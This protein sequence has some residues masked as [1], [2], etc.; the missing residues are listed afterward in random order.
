MSSKPNTIRKRRD[1]LE[2]EGDRSVADVKQLKRHLPDLFDAGF[3][4]E[5]IQKELAGFSS[6]GIGASIKNGLTD[7]GRNQ[8]D[9][10]TAHLASCALEALKKHSF[11]FTVQHESEKDEEDEFVQNHNI[12]VGVGNVSDFLS[13]S[14]KPIEDLD[15]LCDFSRLLHH[16]RSVVD[17][18]KGKLPNFRRHIQKFEV[19]IQTLKGELSD[20][21]EQEKEGTLTRSERIQKEQ[22][23]ADIGKQQLAAAANKKNLKRRQK[24]ISDYEQKIS[25]ISKILSDFLSQFDPKNPQSISEKLKPDMFTGSI[26]YQQADP[27]VLIAIRRILLSKRRGEYSSYDVE[28]ASRHR[29]LKRKEALAKWSRRLALPLLLVSGV[30]LA[31]RERISDAVFGPQLNAEAFAEA[32]LSMPNQFRTEVLLKHNKKLAVTKMRILRAIESPLM[33]NDAKK[34]SQEIISSI[35]TATNPQSLTKALNEVLH[36]INYM[37]GKEDTVRLF[38]D[39]HYVKLLKGEFGDDLSLGL[40]YWNNPENGKPLTLRGNQYTG[41]AVE[42]PKRQ[43]CDETGKFNVITYFE[44]DG[45]TYEVREIADIFSSNSKYDRQKCLESIDDPIERAEK[46]AEY[47]REGFTDYFDDHIVGGKINT[48][49]PYVLASLHVQQAK[50]ES[51]KKSLIE[52]FK[53]VF[54][55]KQIKTIKKADRLS[56]L[57]ALLLE[58]KALSWHS[59]ESQEDGQLKIAINP[60]FEEAFKMVF[61]DDTEV[62]LR[63]YGDTAGLVRSG[64]MPVLNQKEVVVDRELLCRP[65]LLVGPGLFKQGKGGGLKNIYRLFQVDDPIYEGICT[66]GLYPPKNASLDEINQ[67]VEYK[68]KVLSH[69]LIEGRYLDEN[70]RLAFERNLDMSMSEEERRFYVVQLWLTRIITSPKFKEDFERIYQAHSKLG[71]INDQDY[72]YSAAMLE[73]DQKDVEDSLKR[74][75]EDYYFFSPPHDLMVDLIKHFGKDIDVGYSADGEGLFMQRDAQIFHVKKEDFCSN[76]FKT[77]DLTFQLAFGMS[78]TDG[79]RIERKI[80]EQDAE[81][82]FLKACMGKYPLVKG[83]QSETRREEILNH[84]LIKNYLVPREKEAL[85]NADS[86]MAFYRRLNSTVQLLEHDRAR[87]EKDFKKLMRAHYL[88]NSDEIKLFPP[89]NETFKKAVEDQFGPDCTL[90]IGDAGL[91]GS[92]NGA[93]WK[94]EILLTVKSPVPKLIPSLSFKIPTEFLFYGMMLDRS[95]QPKEPYLK[96]AL[97]AEDLANWDPEETIVNSIL[98]NPFLHEY[99]SQEYMKRLSGTNSFEEFESILIEWLESMRVDD[100]PKLQDDLY[101]LMQTIPD[102]AYQISM[103]HTRDKSTVVVRVDRSDKMIRL[104]EGKYGKGIGI[105]LDW[106]ND[107]R[108]YEAL[109]PVDFSSSRLEFVMSLDQYCKKNYEGVLRV[110]VPIPALGTQ[111]II[112]IMSDIVKGDPKKDQQVCPPPEASKKK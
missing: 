63:W 32:G 73:K 44:I 107:D 76:W 48:D 6:Y 43:F 20:L 18:T 83:E 64:D 84:P 90:S 13:A 22:L 5:Q 58:V 81:V 61:G 112:H 42:L 3:Y 45:E 37:N 111:V 51:I 39:P 87:M 8:F 67:F 66:E 77:L 40:T 89:F 95:I 80:T 52:Q 24:K 26:N 100:S 94:G 19:E 104:L 33:T 65:H 23:E 9:A 93:V 7:E 10:Y 1:T 34:Y 109:P 49:D 71:R 74:K 101:E 36:L 17:L 62:Y 85:R 4:L 60:D 69:P 35:L 15:T 38:L 55:K 2:L 86:S 75:P 79:V 57:Q 56:A 53:D 12:T 25:S 59:V 88:F 30:A 106:I 47:I 31:N 11:K 108:P 29:W 110:A 72:R 82:A 41:Y 105:S 54:T 27:D 14:R 98:N 97:T 78:I 21:Q 50:L 96:H 16:F 102:D 70:L 46:E 28:G 91:H 68:K 99:L 92:A 103:Y